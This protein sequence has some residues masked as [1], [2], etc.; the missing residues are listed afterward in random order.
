MLSLSEQAQDHAA[1]DTLVHAAMKAFQVPGASVAVVHGE[2]V[3]YLK[4]FGVRELGKEEPVTPDTLFAIGSTTKAFTTTAIAMLVEDGKLAWD[5]PV[6]KHLPFFRLS[7]P[8]ADANVTLRDLVV[9]RTGISRHDLLWYNSSWEREE[10][11]RKIGLVKSN[12]SFRSTWEYNNIMYLAAGTASGA[13]AGG[14]WEA[15]VQQRIF[16]PLGMTGANFSVTVAQQAPDHASPHEKDKDKNLQVI[17]WRNLDNVAPAG[18]INAGARDL[19]KWIRFQLGEGM[20]EGKRL[21]SATHLAETHTPQMVLRRDEAARAMEPETQ[22]SNYALGWAIQDYHGH[23]LISHGGGID[24]FRAQVA[25]V[26]EAKLGLVILANSAGHAMPEALRNSLLNHLLDFPQ[27]DWNALFTGL[28][29]KGEAEQQAK[30]TEREEK[31]HKETHPS[32]ELTAYTGAYEEPAYGTASVS[33]ENGALAL[34]W[35]NF[36]FPLEHFHFDTFLA[37]S[38]RPRFTEPVVFTL[39]ASG[40]V[41]LLKVLNVEFKKVKPEPEKSK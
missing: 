23:L 22:I 35:I 38:E 24:G 2:E 15:L 20:F 31:R 13:V 18:A 17:P 12:T 5:D 16:D 4:G 3:L 40:D 41:A 8:L 36:H 30:E 19:T 1:L 27:R 39:D 37:K 14:S 28:A 6:R 11:L 10:I 7:D 29:E 25:L 33:L 9:H 32:R 26:P 34:Q 21:L